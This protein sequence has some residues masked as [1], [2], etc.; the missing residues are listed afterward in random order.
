MA[1]NA[2]YCQNLWFKINGIVD[3]R[4]DVE[5]ST[6]AALLFL[7]SLAETFNNNWDL[8]IASYN[9][10]GGYI[11]SQIR[12]QKESNFWKICQI[13]GF[14]NETLEFVPRFYAVLHIL[15]NPE[16]YNLQAPNLSI[17]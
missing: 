13:S 10:G 11:S 3:E 2:P 5:K 1:I 7:K 4:M 8:V 16:K 9:G 15:K 6:R 12:S 14:K 17:P